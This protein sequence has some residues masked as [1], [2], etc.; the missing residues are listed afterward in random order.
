MS[1]NG[2]VVGH[3]YQNNA[4]YKLPSTQRDEHH[5]VTA[6]RLDRIHTQQQEF[7]FACE[8]KP[9]KNGTHKTQFKKLRNT[10]LRLR[11]RK[12]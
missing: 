11:G 6:I 4:F 7:T 5:I 9:W 3:L 12:R 2:S 8:Q 1:F 10:L